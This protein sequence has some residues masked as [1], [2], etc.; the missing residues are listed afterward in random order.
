[1]FS[2]IT[3]HPSTQHMIKGEKNSSQL[4]ITKELRTDFDGKLE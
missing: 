3:T 1:M 4:F 2:S